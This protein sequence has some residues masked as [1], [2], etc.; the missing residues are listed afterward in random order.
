MTGNWCFKDGIISMEDIIQLYQQ[1]FNGRLLTIV[2][3]CCYAGQWVY[4]L[5]DMLENLKI[6]A[7]GHQATKA[8]LALKIIS[9]CQHNETAFDTMYAKECVYVEPTNNLMVFTFQAI[10][11]KQCGRFQ[12][13]AAI[14]TTHITCFSD[15]DEKQCRLDQIPQ[16]AQ[17]SWR[18][19]MKGD[20]R[21]KRLQLR[22]FKVWGRKEHQPYWY[23][24]IIFD[25][26]FEDFC[27]VAKSNR[28]YDPG[29]YGH[30]VFSGYGKVPPPEIERLFSKCG[31][32][33]VNL[34]KDQPTI[35]GSH[36]HNKIRNS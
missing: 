35:H 27:Q 4:R 1:H 23:F 15:Q 5:A 28:D 6:G 8:G 30:I 10:E 14:D 33:P 31:P 29:L 12:T 7:C 25:D 16:R 24:V 21:N 32:T 36:V 9:A 2:S 20:D 17:W 19:L 18:D 34:P 22:L 13:P 26:K 11:I 3:D